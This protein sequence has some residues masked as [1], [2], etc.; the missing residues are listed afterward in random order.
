MLLYTKMHE[1]DSTIMHFDPFH[2]KTGRILCYAQHVLHQREPFDLERVRDLSLD[3]TVHASVQHVLRAAD[4][5][6]P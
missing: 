4:D 2:T 1:K 3:R 6:N 5:P